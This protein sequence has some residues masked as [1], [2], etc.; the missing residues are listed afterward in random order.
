MSSS[1]CCTWTYERNVCRRAVARDDRCIFHLDNKTSVEADQFCRAFSEELQRFEKAEEPIIDFRG[2]VF[3]VDLQLKDHV[4]EKRLFL[5][6]ATFLRRAQFAGA[7]FSDGAFF[8]D[9]LFSELAG[10]SGATFSKEAIFCEAIILGHAAFHDV[11]FRGFTNFSEVKFKGYAAFDKA[12]FLGDAEFHYATFSDDVLFDGARFGR[13]AFRDTKFHGNLR[14]GARFDGSAVFERALFQ[15]DTIESSDLSFLLEQDPYQ[16]MSVTSFSGA[17]VGPSG[18]V[19]FIQPR[20]YNSRLGVEMNHAIDRVSFLNA[21]LVGFNFQEVEW[22][23]YHG[24]RAVVDEVL[25]SIT[26]FENVTPEQVRQICARLRAN[27][28]KAFRYAEAGDF[29]I[30]E[31]D[32]R[33]RWLRGKGWRAIPERLLLWIFSGLSR[34]GESISRPALAAFILIFSLAGL[35]LGLHESSEWQFCQP[36]SFQESLT[37]SVA[38][39][40]QL[41]STALWTD[42]LE[43]LLSIPILGVL[44][45]ALRRKLERRS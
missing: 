36:L 43:R 5:S 7:T 11:Q 21:D 1:R 17:T 41:R 26:P 16:N 32:M 42:T 4:F 22:G 14:V 8:N 45:I 44:F 34:Y 20:E 9:A 2:F 37:R 13:V 29:F 23:R 15:R 6:G 25:M 27:E 40:F 28:E 30:G 38:S 3:P 33:R 24:R 35:R 18:D 19:L 39:F 10:F 12:E 31:M